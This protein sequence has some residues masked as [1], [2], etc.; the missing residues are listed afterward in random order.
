MLF[1]CQNQTDTVQIM[2]TI[3][4]LKEYLT[5]T[6]MTFSYKAVMVL[7][8]L[9]AI[10]HHGKSSRATLIRNVHAFYLDRQRRGLPAE[11]DRERPSPLIRP[12]EV[13]DEQIWQ[14]LTRYPLDLMDAFIAV[15][16]D[17]VRIKS[18]LWSQMSAADLIEL[19]EIALRRIE[20]YYED[21]E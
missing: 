16:D 11:K 14:I 3:D 15:E 12:D 6:H 8:L 5:T 13:T 10:D 20:I 18:A 19:K 1:A 9:N 2:T 4:A 7:A 21:A 17:D